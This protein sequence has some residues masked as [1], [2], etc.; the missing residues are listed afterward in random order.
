MPTIRALATLLPMILLPAALA[1]PVEAQRPLRIF[2]STDMEGVGGIGSPEMVSRSGKDYDTGRRLM[3]AEVNAV[4]AAI[5]RHGPAEILVNDS[6]GDHQNLLHT[7]LDPRVEY[8]QGSIKPL[9]MV[10]GLDGTFDGAI[11]LGYHARA[12]TPTG[13][14][15][16]TGSGR[17]K[18]LWLNDIEVGE[19]GLNA[20]FAGAHGV[21]VLVAAG[22]SRF[23]TQFGALVDAITVATKTAETAQ[24]AR[25]IHPDRV[26]ERLVE[27]VGRALPDVDRFQPLDIGEPVRIRMRFDREVHAEILQ[28]IPGVEQQDDG[29]SVTYTASDMDEAYRLIRL[30][31][32]FI[33]V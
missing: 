8:I 33:D 32:R 27:A 26:R 29:F 14:L 5:L 30:M 11:F 12:G 15:S 2:I 18:G 13:F 4:A 31:Y 24:S 19:G 23:A 9:G 3:T 16:H 28:S 21:P 20:A 25:L 7:E 22:D 10:Q 17:V 1:P 6:H